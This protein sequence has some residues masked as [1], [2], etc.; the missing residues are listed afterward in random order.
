MNGT[1]LCF[2][3]LKIARGNVTVDFDIPFDGS[4]LKEAENLAHFLAQEVFSP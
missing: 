3:Q 2:L 1:P 4:C